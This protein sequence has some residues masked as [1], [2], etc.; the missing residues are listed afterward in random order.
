MHVWGQKIPPLSE[1]V[2]LVEMSVSERTIRVALA[3]LALG[4]SGCASPGVPKPPSL[5]LPE[6][7]SN[8]R[9]ERVGAEVRLSWSTPANTTDGEA[10]RGAMAASVCRGTLKKPCTPVRDQAVVPGPTQWMDALPGTLR[11]GADS[12]LEYRVELKNDRG[13]SAGA[14]EPVF[15]AG[16]RA[17]EVPAG[18]VAQA[19]REGVLVTWEPEQGGAAGAIVEVE[20]TSAAQAGAPKKAPKREPAVMPFG[21]QK[22]ADGPL[23]LVADGSAEAH[24]MLDRSAKSGETYTYTA[25]RVRKVRVAGHALEV[26][27]AAASPVTIIFRN[28]F[29]PVA[30]T[31]LATVPGGGFGAAPAVDLSWQAS[32]ETDVAGYNVYRSIDGGAPGRLARVDVAAYRD[33][34]VL[35]GHTYEY[36]VTAVDAHGNESAQSAAARESLR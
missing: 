20:R 17:P 33:L 12:L 1:C 16:G 7:A 28:T 8:L 2:R 14:S 30:P 18:V 25:Q 9:A 13:R 6:K 21:G 35:P 15:A 36:K 10:M 29:P 32:D 27:S 34:Q 3:G 31:G 4:L 23:I 26:R 5:H 11:V 22:V 24:G 19:R